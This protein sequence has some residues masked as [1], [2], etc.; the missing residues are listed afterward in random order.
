MDGN[1]IMI[2][3]W[4]AVFLITLIVELSTQALVSIWFTIGAIVAAALTYVPN[5]PWWGEVIV[6]IGV[7]I[8]SY[9]LIRPYATDKLKSFKSR[10]NVDSLIGKKGVVIKKISNLEKGEVKINGTIWNAIKREDDKEIDKG[11][12][13]EV[14]SIQGNK[15]L[16][17]MIH[18][19]EN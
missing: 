5:M 13:I 9:L 2:I 7:S 15:L 14:I 4:S 18:K 16:V 10:T 6:F 17:K 8:I 3:V 19:E 1:L 12:I 11:A